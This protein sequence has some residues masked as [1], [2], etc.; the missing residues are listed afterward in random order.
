[1]F[2]PLAYVEHSQG[3]EHNLSTGLL[4]SPHFWSFSDAQSSSVPMTAYQRSHCVPT[5][6]V[7]GHPVKS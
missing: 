4:S 6:G 5:Q 7:F 2:I 3:T 1:M